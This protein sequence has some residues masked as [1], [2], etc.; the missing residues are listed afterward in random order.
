MIIFVLKSAHCYYQMLPPAYVIN[1][2]ARPERWERFKK[3]WEGSIEMIRVP[4]I[5]QQPGYI[6]CKKSH[7][8]CIKMAKERGDPF[9]FVME[10][11]AAPYPGLTKETIAS[12]WSDVV[13]NLG[14]NLP[15]WDIVL[16]ATSMATLGGIHSSEL[17]TDS[18]RV[19]RLPFSLAAHWILY[20]QSIYDMV[21][22]WEDND[23]VWI[24]KEFQ[25]DGARVF[26]TLPFL[27]TQHIG[28]SDIQNDSRDY[29]YLFQDAENRLKAL[30]P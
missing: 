24:D 15:E 6:G 22:G 10:D 25:E 16:G 13:G 11:D 4:A 9:V 23:E 14:S 2:D 19:M 12:L 7:I 17:S 18:V 3:D 28:H 21:I 20:N 26:V 8:K 29:S 30:Y 5:I 1:S 27:A